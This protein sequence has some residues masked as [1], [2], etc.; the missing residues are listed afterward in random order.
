MSTITDYRSDDRDAVA[1]E[2]VEHGLKRVQ[3]D[4]VTTSKELKSPPS[5]VIKG[6]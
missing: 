4:I 1:S 6:C 2:K 3:K 5:K